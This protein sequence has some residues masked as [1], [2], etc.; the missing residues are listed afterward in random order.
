MTISNS[1]LFSSFV[2]LFFFFLF[3]FFPTNK[4]E[5]RPPRK[6]DFQTTRGSSQPTKDGRM[7]RERRDHP[8]KK[9]KRD[10]PTKRERRDRP[11]KKGRGRPATKKEGGRGKT[12]FFF[13]IFSLFLFLFFCFGL[14]TTP[15]WLAS[16]VDREVSLYP[17]WLGGGLISLL[18]WRSSFR[19]FG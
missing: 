10:R 9:R 2:I 1:S 3:L 17:S 12:V 11:T 19:L 15:S 5:G 6:G 14:F 16:L 8:T 4:E 7:G 13:P 18:V